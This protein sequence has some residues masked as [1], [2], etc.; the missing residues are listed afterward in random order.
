MTLPK[1]GSL[2]GGK[3][4]LNTFW[5]LALPALFWGLILLLPQSLNWEARATLAVTVC[6]ILLWALEV[7]PFGLT[8]MLTAVVLMWL[9]A[10]PTAIIFSGFASPAVFLVIS[11]MMMAAA[12]NETPLG[13][14]MTYNILARTG[15]ST[16]GI[17]LGLILILQIQAFI[18]PATAVRVALLLPL[19]LYLIELLEARPGSNLRRLI[20]LAVAF[21]G[22]ISGTAVL[23]SA[24]GN[25]I[26]VELIYT[27]LGR[28]ISYTDWLLYTLPLWIMIIPAVW[29]VLLKVY[30]PE[31][32]SFP[33]LGEAMNQKI[34]ELGLVGPA[35]KRCIAILGLTVV[36][37][38]LE[39][40]HGLHP[41]I[42]AMLAVV[43][44]TLPGLG[45]TSFDKVVQINYH[46]VLVLGITLSLGN[47][48][49][50]TGAITYLGNL[51]NTDWVIS[52][53]QNP[54]WA[55]GAVVIATQIYHLAVTNV[56]TT[57]VT[58]IPIVITLAMSAGV[59]PAPLAFAAGLT[60]L[61]G[62]LLIVET[63]PNM[64]AHSTGLI[65]QREFLIPGFWATIAVIC[66]TLL[67]AATWWKWL[68]LI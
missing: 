51:M 34:V 23:P 1:T 5:V 16:R 8:A 14:R 18:I 55:V 32:D 30:P 21:G 25:I 48:L 63:L 49:N 13:K 33:H 22:N 41:T 62:F 15:G 53:L 43:L 66:C 26:T 40:L 65:S 37:W 39:P 20:L 46:T 47:A 67:V 36:L 42:P 54:L 3:L 59:D 2:P 58:F 19:A 6:A 68:G 7:I 27:Y 45:V 31:K 11:G 57:V 9:K 24:I 35:E 10:V 28:Q 52:V 50:Q 44:L 60:S 17:I 12:V 64:L 29:L 38:L 56:A 61:F 4:S